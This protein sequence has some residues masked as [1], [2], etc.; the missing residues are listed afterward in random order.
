MF[1]ELSGDLDEISALHRVAR[2][3]VGMI[4]PDAK[5]HTIAPIGQ[6]EF[7]IRFLLA[8]QFGSDCLEL[9]M[10]ASFHR[11]VRDGLANLPQS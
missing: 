9:H 10:N 11:T 7:A 4:A 3:I 1:K 6:G 8:C 2:F 5:S